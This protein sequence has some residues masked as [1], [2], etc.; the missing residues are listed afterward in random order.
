MK[1]GSL[2]GAF[3]ELLPSRVQKMFLRMNEKAPR[4]LRLQTIGMPDDSGFSRHM[5]NI[6]SEIRVVLRAQKTKSGSRQPA[7]ACAS[8]PGSEPIDIPLLRADGKVN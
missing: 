6:F 1:S 8:T 7:A 2:A 5:N 4:F 3:A